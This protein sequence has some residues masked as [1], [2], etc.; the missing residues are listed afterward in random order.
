M[1]VLFLS[2]FL[3]LATVPL[4]PRGSQDTTVLLP[5]SPRISVPVAQQAQGR[6][7]RHNEGV[8]LI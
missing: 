4:T 8:E 6:P 7:S 1:L 2:R 3:A 5:W